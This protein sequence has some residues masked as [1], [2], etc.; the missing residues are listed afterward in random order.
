MKEYLGLNV[1]EDRLGVLQDTHW[2]S[3]LIGYFPTYTIGNLAS[4]QLFNKAVADLPSIPDDIAQGR[5]ATLLGWLR[6]NVH[7]H[8]RKYLPA[9]LIHLATGQPLSAKPYLH[10]LYGKYQEI[11]GLSL[12]LAPA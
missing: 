11:Y 8:A 12:P 1:P 2:A 7:Q 10:Y 5:F 4:A 6:Q 3:G 9:D